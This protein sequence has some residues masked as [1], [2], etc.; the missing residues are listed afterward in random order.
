MNWGSPPYTHCRAQPRPSK[1]SL[2][3][4]ARH[5]PSNTSRLVIWTHL[6]QLK[7]TMDKD[8]PERNGPRSVTYNEIK[9][10][11]LTVA[12][13]VWN[14][15]MASFFRLMP[16]SLQSHWS[17]RVSFDVERYSKHIRNSRVNHNDQVAKE[18]EHLN[19]FYTQQNG[20]EHK[21]PMEVVECHGRILLWHL[22]DARAKES[23]VCTRI[24]STGF[25]GIKQCEIITIRGNR[26][27]V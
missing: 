17:V 22:W 9:R 21:E 20:G 25:E 10:I 7:S 24:V 2:M 27:K 15:V 1:F 16:I 12:C 8:I 18:L 26:V 19:K 5:N 3:L 14:P 4:P 6:A 23:R 13:A 11:V